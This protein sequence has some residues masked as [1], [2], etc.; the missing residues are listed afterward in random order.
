[1]TEICY[2]VKLEMFN[3]YNPKYIINDQMWQY[4]SPKGPAI[5]TFSQ[6]MGLL[7]VCFK[8]QEVFALIWT[9]K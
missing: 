6:P 2:T 7:S 4:R 8:V 3:M 5:H 1:M 9:L